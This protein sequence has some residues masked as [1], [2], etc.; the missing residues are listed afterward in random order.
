MIGPVVRALR[1]R[2][3]QSQELVARGVG[4]ALRT[5][6]GWENEENNPGYESIVSLHAYFKKFIPELTF[7][8]ILKSTR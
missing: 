2:L 6:A 1:L 5:Y 4:V 8:E 3:G 7:D